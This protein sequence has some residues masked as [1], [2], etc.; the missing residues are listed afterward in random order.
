[1]AQAALNTA[2]DRSSRLKAG[3]FQS[4]QRPPEDLPP[5]ANNNRAF[6]ATNTVAG[7]VGRNVAADVTGNVIDLE[8]YRRAQFIAG[9]ASQRRQ[10]PANNNNAFEEQQQTEELE[11]AEMDFEEQQLEQSRIAQYLS[12]TLIARNQFAQQDATQAQKQKETEE[13]QEFVKKEAKAAAKRGAIAV[14][15]LIAAALDISSAGLSFLVDFFI[16]MFTLGWL[17]LEMIYGTHIA[18]KKSK[19]ISPISWAPIPMPVDKDAIILQ[20][21]IITADILL[22]IA[23]VSLGFFAMCILHDITMVVSQTGTVIGSGGSNLC[24]G[25]AALSMLGI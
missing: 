10:Q 14:V 21:F 18:K 23:V 9:Q 19:Y 13:T 16:Y 7:G 11:E 22:L 15:D 24:L 4:Q 5:A 17:N 20:A 2:A 8:S 1:M 6:A 3:R 12:K 25:S